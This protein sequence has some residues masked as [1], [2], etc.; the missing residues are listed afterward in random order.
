MPGQL[1]RNSKQIR[2]DDAMRAFLGGDEDV[3]REIL[4]PLVVDDPTRRRET[5][6]L[7]QYMFASALCTRLGDERARDVNLYLRSFELPQIQLFNLM[8]TRLPIV[9][10][11]RQV[12]NVLL[13]RHLAGQDEVTL[14]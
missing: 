2:L 8:A 9:G 4:T 3:A 11:A 1:V 5:E 10:L 14:L 6:A 7:Q 13:E 12:A